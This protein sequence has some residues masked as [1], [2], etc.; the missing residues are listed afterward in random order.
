MKKA[1]ILP[2]ILISILLTFSCS[3][4][5]VTPQKPENQKIWRNSH[6]STEQA[7]IS[8]IQENAE[9]KETQDKFFSYFLWLIATIV[10]GAVILVLL[11]V[12]ES[13]QKDKIIYNSEQFL[14]HSI[15]VQEAE[16][17]RISCELH[18][19]V[20]QSMRYVSLLAENLSDKEMAAKIISVQNENI[21]N[22]RKLCYNLTPPAITGSN[23]ISSIALLGQKIFDTNHTDFQFK[24]VC[25]PSVNFEKKNDDELMNIYRIVQEALQNIQKHAKASETTVFFKEKD[26][27]LKIIITDDGCGISETLLNQINS[28]FFENVESMHFGLRN[29]F[30]RV[31]FLGG[32]L[33]FF[34]EEGCGTRITVEI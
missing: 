21:E 14:Q 33:A 8:L 27:I 29:I 22:I 12:R 17:K 4:G 9:L 23:M 18:D 25:E 6:I 34:S 30:E 5:K 19:T 3:P 13:K 10:V 28:G 32:K 2:L 24:V 11:N 31:K 16:R 26:G 1:K 20:A 15:L 7:I